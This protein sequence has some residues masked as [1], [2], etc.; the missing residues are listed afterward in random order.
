MKK[1]LENGGILIM[2]C[3]ERF[4]KYIA[5]S[6]ASDEDSTESP[7]TTRQ[8]ELSRRLAEEMLSLGLKNVHM[9]SCGNAIGTLPATEGVKAAGTLALVAHVDTSP[10]ASGEGVNAREVLYTG[11]DIE[12]GHGVIL[13]EKQFPA[14]KDVRGQVLLVTDGSTL[15]GADDKAGVA[16]IMTAVEKIIAS[17]AP[18]GELRIVFTTDEEV[19]RGTEGLDVKELAC[20]WGYTVDGGEL[21]VYEYENFNAAAALVRVHG[22]GIHPGSAKNIMK[23]AATI[24]MELHSLLP[25]DQVPE[26]TEGY[27]GFIHLT[28]MSGDVVEAELHYII[29]DHDR[30]LFEEKKACLRAAVGEINRRYGEGTAEA[31]I[32]DTYYNMR[33]KIEPHRHLLDRAEAAYRAC[34][35]APRT[36]AIRGG[37]D[38]AVLTWMGLPCPNLSTGGYNSHGVHEFIPV[39]SLA[40]MPDVLLEIIGSFVENV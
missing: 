40:V 24:A 27:E 6:T 11:E 21:G 30:T 28:D 4:L 2:T 7:S 20:D 15:L 37:T 26:K 38:G 35:V 39:D 14:M 10:A 31:D 23:N 22:V 25:A 34:G 12:L 8:L 9:D 33:E 5:V 18:H 36:E 29:R 16:E 17:G 32:S 19:G 1:Q 3:K 13:S